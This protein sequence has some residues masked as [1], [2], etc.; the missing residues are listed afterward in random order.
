[1]LTFTRTREEDE[2][3]GLL[4]MATEADEDGEYVSR[5]DKEEEGTTA[6]SAASG[7]DSTPDSTPAPAPAPAPAPVPAPA[8]ADTGVDVDAFEASASFAGARAGYVFKNGAQGVG[9]YKD[10][11]VPGSSTEPAAPDAPQQPAFIP[12]DV[13]TGSR[14]D[15][16]YRHGEQGPGYYW[17]DS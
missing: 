8:A 10:T 6:A 3:L 9:Y 7:S 16:S 1:M 17:D 11:Y 13:F 12:S 4:D 15:Y 5:A 2:A 14:D